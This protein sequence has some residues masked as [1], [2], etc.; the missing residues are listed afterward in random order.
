MNT[1]YQVSGY[2]AHATPDNFQNGCSSDIK[3]QQAPTFLASAATLPE[4]LVILRNEFKAP[5]NGVTLDAY[6]E[7]GRVDIQ[8]YQREAFQVATP[9][10]ATLQAWR[11]GEIDLY[12]TDYSF[13]VERIESGFSLSTI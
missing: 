8:V 12:L 13:Q 3:F 1:L 7:L 9:S 6:N 11:N 4:L 10:A 5:V 2:I